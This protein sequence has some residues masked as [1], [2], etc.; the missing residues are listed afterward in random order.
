MC[1]MVIVDRYECDMSIYH[2]ACLVVVP[3]LSH[4]YGSYLPFEDQHGVEFWTLSLIHP[5]HIVDDHGRVWSK[6][7]RVSMGIG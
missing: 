3:S 7:F 5:L 6:V 4:P 1:H 2:Q